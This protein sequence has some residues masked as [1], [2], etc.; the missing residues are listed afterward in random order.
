MKRLPKVTCKTDIPGLWFHGVQE[1]G[2]TIFSTLSVPEISFDYDDQNPAYD[3]LCANGF[4]N[5]PKMY[6][7]NLTGFPY[8]HSNF[9][10]EDVL[11]LNAFAR[12][13]SYAVLTGYDASKSDEENLPYVAAHFQTRS[14]CYIDNINS[15]GLKQNSRIT[16]FDD[17]TVSFDYKCDSVGRFDYD[18]IDPFYPAGYS[19]LYSQPVN[20]TAYLSYQIYIVNVSGGCILVTGRPE[21]SHID[22]DTGAVTGNAN[23]FTGILQIDFTEWHSVKIET[24]QKDQNGSIIFVYID[25]V[26]IPFHTNNTAYDR[27]DGGIDTDS[28]HLSVSFWGFNTRN[29][30]YTGDYWYKN[31]RIANRPQ[32]FEEVRWCVYHG[33]EWQYYTDNHFAFALSNLS[34]VYQRAG[35]IRWQGKSELSENYLSTGPGRLYINVLAR[36]CLTLTLAYDNSSEK[37]GALNYPALHTVNMTDEQLQITDNSTIYDRVYDVGFVYWPLEENDQDY[38][39]NDGTYQ[40]LIFVHP[41]VDNASFIDNWCVITPNETNYITYSIS[42][43]KHYGYSIE[44]FMRI[45]E[46]DSAAMSGA[47]KIMRLNTFNVSGLYA[48]DRAFWF[49]YI[50]ALNTD[51]DVLGYWAIFSAENVIC[52]FPH[53]KNKAVSHLAFRMVPEN[54]SD[55]YFRRLCVY[56]NGSLAFHIYLQNRSNLTGFGQLFDSAGNSGFSGA[57][58]GLRLIT[59]QEVYPAIVDESR[60]FFANKDTFYLQDVFSDI[61]LGLDRYWDR[62]TEVMADPYFDPFELYPD[63]AFPKTSNDYVFGKPVITWQDERTGEELGTG[64]ITEEITRNSKFRGDFSFENT[65]KGISVF[66]PPEGY[67][68]MTI[69]RQMPPVT[70][71]TTESMTVYKGSYIILDGSGSYDNITGYLWSTGSTAAQISVQIMETTTFTLTVTNANGSDSATITIVCKEVPE[72]VKKADIVTVQVTG[73]EIPLSPIPYQELSVLLNGQNCIISLRQLGLFLYCS[74]SVD[75]R[76]IFNNIMCSINARVNV[77]RSP[78]FTGILKFYDTQGTDRPHYSELG[79]RWILVYRAEELPGEVD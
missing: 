11:P 35:D 52:K 30:Y 37:F 17:F 72:I 57:I 51:H 79:S 32:H 8:F 45:T 53:F 41:H 3:Y 26:L 77:F 33:N 43:V 48:N 21:T 67:I 18:Y 7:E 9:W 5:F 74:L 1:Y 69:N 59:N 2:H 16:N 13:V 60:A 44:L 39:A 12:G 24:I 64:S 73:Q 61:E 66:M 75:G 10:N 20:T 49:G 70:V 46:T 58:R 55:Y 78:Y 65:A 40:T 29:A 22:Y 27:T 47:V 23:Y 38:Y 31:F 36:Y 34:N 6:R 14:Q 76:Q 15:G 62:V 42:N 25:N 50:P 68:E 56:I 19:F 71:I 4:M 63:Y 28:G 54:A